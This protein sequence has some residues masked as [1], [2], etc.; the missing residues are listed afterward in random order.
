MIFTEEQVRQLAAQVGFEVKEEEIGLLTTGFNRTL[1]YVA[2]I[3]EAPVA[4]PDGAGPFKQS[5]V[6]SNGRTTA[7][8]DYPGQQPEA[9]AEQ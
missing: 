7:E 8:S 5:P 9:G 1:Q 4:R 3:R 2:R 6:L